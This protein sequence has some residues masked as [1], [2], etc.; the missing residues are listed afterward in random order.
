MNL[1]NVFLGIV[2]ILLSQHAGLSQVRLPKIVG[3]G[4]I[5]QRNTPV[6]IWGWAVE[7]EKI[8]V[9]FNNK[10][11]SAVAD[12]NGKWKVALSPAKEGGP[13]VMNIDASNHI[14]LSDI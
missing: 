6:T 4:M 10:T 14:T 5:L 8:T 2:S 7:G 9:S 3:N 1:R 11:Y 12:G 13:Y